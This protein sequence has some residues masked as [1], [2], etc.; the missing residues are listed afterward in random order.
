MGRFIA[1]RA[2]KPEWRDIFEEYGIEQALLSESDGLT[3][4]LRQDGWILR[5]QEPGG[6]V[7]LLSP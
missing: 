1:A 2:G 5:Y 4:A 3:T 7:V 6:W